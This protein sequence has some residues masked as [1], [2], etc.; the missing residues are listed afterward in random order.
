MPR[1]ARASQGGICYHV[2]N[3]GNAKAVIFHDGLDC[4]AFVRL[5]RRAVERRPMRVL[6]YCVMPNHVHLVLWPSGDDDLGPWMH[7][8]LTAHVRQHHQRHGTTGRVWQGRFKAFPIQ[9]DEH[10][11]TVIRYVE[12]NPLRAG[13]VARAED[14][15]WSS[16]RGRVA[17]RSDGV[18]TDPPVPLGG[19]W[20]AWVQE[21]LTAAELESLRE[22]V[23][24]QRPFGD[25]AWTRG[26]AE[27]LGLGSSLK[28]LGRPPCAV[29]SAVRRQP[30]VLK[31]Q[32]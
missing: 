12:R 11:L 29:A 7:W 22:S 14:W 16:L 31:G 24:R 17:G 10:L 5:V 30:Q 18:L 25:P 28:A 13:L 8:L 6:A 1:T 32:N 23:R 3:R 4:E 2:I 27:R 19:D 26:A 9:R 21:P 20:C 15:P